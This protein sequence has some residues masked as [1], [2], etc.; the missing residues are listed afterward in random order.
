M[1]LGPPLNFCTGIIEF[2]LLPNPSVVTNKTGYGS[3]WQ[4]EISRVAKK[5]IG[6]V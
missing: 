3:S 1:A 6:A 2:D 4:R 5:L